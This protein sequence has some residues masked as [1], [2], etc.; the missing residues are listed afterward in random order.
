MTMMP[1]IEMA[2]K[3]VPW[4]LSEPVPVLTGNPRI[5]WVLVWVWVW[6]WVWLWRI[7]D[8]FN[9]VCGWRWGWIYPRH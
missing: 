4:V 1:N 2:N 6:V 5:D 9:W 3:P 8:F 7:P